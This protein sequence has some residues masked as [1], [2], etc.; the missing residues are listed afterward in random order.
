MVIFSVDSSNQA[1]EIRVFVKV[2]TVTVKKVIYI[3]PVVSLALG[4][5]IY[6]VAENGVE[7]KEKHRPRKFVEVKSL[8]D[9]VSFQVPV[10]PSDVE[11]NCTE[12]CVLVNHGIEELIVLKLFPENPKISVQRQVFICVD[13]KYVCE[14]MYITVFKNLE[15]FIHL[16]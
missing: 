7:A 5:S 9:F 1:Q 14:L 2:F 3:D 12:N 11:G 16:L 10:V 8:A 15:L 6:L 4:R 13:S